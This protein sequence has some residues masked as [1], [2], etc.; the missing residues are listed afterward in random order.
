MLANLLRNVKVKVKVWVM[1]MAMVKSVMRVLH[2]F[3][4]IDDGFDVPVKAAKSTY[5]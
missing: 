2:Q 4:H 3:A 5:V 1:V